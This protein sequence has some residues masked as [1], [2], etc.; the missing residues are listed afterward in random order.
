MGWS[1]ETRPASFKCWID[2]MYTF[3]NEATS[4]RLLAYA[5][6]DMRVVYSVIEV[7]DKKTGSVEVVPD[8][9]LVRFNREKRNSDYLDYNFCYKGVG[10]DD[11]Y[12][13]CPK[14]LLTRLT[15]QTNERA[16]KWVEACWNWHLNNAARPKLTKGTIFATA[17]PI[18]FT[19]GLKEQYFQVIEGRGLRALRG[20]FSTR[21]S[22][23]LRDDARV[24]EVIDTVPAW[25]AP[26]MRL[27]TAWDSVNNHALY[28]LHGNNG[29]FCLSRKDPRAA[30]RPYESASCTIKGERRIDVGDSVE[31]GQLSLF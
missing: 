20:A 21:F 18:S 16:A 19:N 31:K 27:E 9:M 14:D 23:Q 5:L 11:Y 13:K 29:E 2:R 30:I 12:I 10:P 26:D 15:P 6:K 22:R 1:C 8:V 3:E 25:F 7:T 4:N 17:K 28:L 24:L